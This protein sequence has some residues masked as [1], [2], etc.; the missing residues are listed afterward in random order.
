MDTNMN[1]KWFWYWINLLETL[2]LEQLVYAN[3]LSV[4]NFMK[5]KWSYI[6]DKHLVSK[7]GYVVYVKYS[8]DFEGSMKKV[9]ICI[10]KY[11][12]CWSDNIWVIF[13]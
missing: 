6:S 1:E 8:A 10:L 4:V 12:L 3:Q 7:L 5:P 2:C 11:T 9:T 13:G